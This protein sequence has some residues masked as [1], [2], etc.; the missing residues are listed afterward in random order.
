VLT[1]GLE[2]ERKHK[3]E[4]L[5]EGLILVNKYQIFPH[6]TGEKTP[7]MLEELSEQVIKDTQIGL[8]ITAK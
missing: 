5:V 2:R 3:T 4:Q 7:K 1:L 6:G 8:D